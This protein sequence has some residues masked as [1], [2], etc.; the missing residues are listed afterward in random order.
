MGWKRTLAP[1]RN[2]ITEATSL[3]FLVSTKLQRKRNWP[4]NCTKGEEAGPDHPEM[5]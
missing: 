1:S 5:V 2:A 4:R 3:S